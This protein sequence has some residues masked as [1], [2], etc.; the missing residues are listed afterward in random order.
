MF[1]FFFSMIGIAING[2]QFI[3]FRFLGFP[4]IYLIIGS[5][6]V[7]YIRYFFVNKGV[8]SLKKGEK[9]LLVFELYGVFLVAFSL[10]GGNRY[11]TNNELYVSLSYI[12]R[13]A[14]YLAFL[15]A[16]ILFQDEF[17]T[18]K[19][20]SFLKQ[21]GR[22]SFWIIYFAHIIVMRQI[23]VS[24]PTEMLLGWLALTTEETNHT[25]KGL[26][27]FLVIMLT[28]VAIGG[29]ITNMLIRVM[30]AACFFMYRNRKALLF[31]LMKIG[32]CIMLIGMFVLPFFDSVFSSIFD[33]NS[34]W[35]L[36]Y[37]KD[38]LNSL[39]QSRF[40]GV[41][42]GTSYASKRF[43]GG[44]LNIVGGP[45]GATAEYTTM[46]KLFVTGPHSSFVAVAF[47]LG[48][49]GIITFV[50][51]LKGIYNGMSNLKQNVSA[52]T[53]FAFWAAL[54]IISTNVG[55]E[56]PYYLMLF[57]FAMGKSVQ[58]IRSLEK[59]DNRT[60]TLYSD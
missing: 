52:A 23:V 6:F 30:Y 19:L 37:W 47:R 25:R 38:E 31:Q 29:E 11:F 35:R 7:S 20:D 57:V 32:A 54:I 24:V 13:Q 45:F 43:V 15:P 50:L 22:V 12:P 53:F 27:R 49:I 58:E 59:T 10:V 41:G 48:L 39:I 26:F 42:Y 46:E 34:F 18:N 55:L 8:L 60:A 5:L 4:I 3:R 33:A 2:W 51:F 9:Y 56:S 21:Y 40:V 16:I 36:R 28:P 17:Y 44:S 14:F 1:V